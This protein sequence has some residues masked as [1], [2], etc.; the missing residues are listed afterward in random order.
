MTCDEFIT[1]Y[2]NQYISLEKE[3]T[4][5]LYY[6]ALDEKN[7]NAYSQAYSK[8]MLEIGS[9]ID[10]IFKEY[11]RLIDRNFKGSFSTIGR[12][13]D[14]IK[15]NDS[16]FIT[17]VVKLIHY[18]Y[19]LR[20]CIDF[21]TEQQDSPVWWTV[22]NKVKHNRTSNVEIDG[23]RQE[24]Y[25][26]ANQRY[27]VFALAGLYQIMVNYYYRLAGSEGKQIVTPMPGSRVFKMTGGVWDSIIF[28]GDNALYIND[29]HLIWETSMINY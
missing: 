5:T 14:C 3:F 20:P 11:C 26:F 19:S 7:A 13:K 1:I 8:L 15:K 10:V 17:Q 25:R 4:A 6:L 29:D 9:E 27:T 28:Y 16:D 24:G 12:Y 18:D 21:N 22:Y 2:W 23:I